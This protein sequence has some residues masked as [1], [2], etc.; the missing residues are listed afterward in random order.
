[1]NVLKPRLAMNYTLFLLLLFS[2]LTFAQNQKRFWMSPASV[3]ADFWTMFEPNTSWDTLRSRIDVFSIHVNAFG[4]RDTAKMW[5]A[6]T[7]LRNAGV[8]VNIEAG[9][10]RPFSGCD[11]LAGER[12]A[13]L[14]LSQMQRWLQRGG[15]I[16]FVTMD[17]PINTMILNG[18]PSG[19]CNW[20]VQR[21]ANEMVDYMK[22]VRAQIPGVVFALVEPVPWY[23]VGSFPPHPGNNYG[24]LLKTLDTVL[25][26]IAQ[27]GETLGIF[28][29]D[30]PYEYGQ[31]SFTKGWKKIKAVEDWLHA[32]GIRHGRIHNSQEGGFTSDSLFFERTLDSRRQYKAVGGDEDEIEVWCWYAHPA[33]NWPETQPFTFA[34]TCKKF[35]EQASQSKVFATLEP[36]DGKVYHGIQTVFGGHASYIATLDS[37]TQPAVRGIFMDVPGSRPPQ[38]NFNGLR[39]FLNDAKKIGY[40]PEVSLFLVTS[41][42][43]PTGATDS[44]IALTT[45]HDEF[46]DSIVTI[47]KTFGGKLFLR[48]GGEFNGWWNGGGYHPYLYPKAFQKIV[49]LCAAKDFRDSVATVWCYYPAAANDFDS[50]DAKGYRWYPGDGYVDWFGLDLFD[51][52]DF[53]PALPDY[54]RGIITR[55]GKS[56]RFLSMARSKG[57]PVFLNETS[58][59]GV[60]I[61]SDPQDGV[62]DWNAW[63]AKFWQFIDNHQEVKGFNYIN[64]HWDVTGFP[65]W[66]DA[67]IENNAYVT[68]QYQAEMRKPKY[69]HLP[70][71]TAPT[72]NLPQQVILIAPANNTMT[73]DSSVNLVWNRSAPNVDL[74]RIH[75]T[76]DASF[77]TLVMNDSTVTDTTR[78][79]GGMTIGSVY[80]WRVQAH[81]ADGW[82]AFSPTWTF[83]RTLDTIPRVPPGMVV[84][85]SP[86]DSSEVI[87]SDVTLVWHRQ[88]P[89]VTR[90]HVQVARDARF[91]NLVLDDVSV[92]DTIRAF[93]GLTQ[94]STYFWRVRAQNV[95]GY[96]PYS[97]VWTFTRKDTT[98]FNPKANVIIDPQIV[99]QTIEGWGASSNFFEEP[100][101]RLPERTRNEIFDLVFEDLGANILCIRL[102]SDFQTSKN[103][104]YNWDVMA[105]QR[106]I[107]NEALRR[108]NIDF[109]W[110]KISSPPGW[111]KT[112]NS[113]ANGGSVKPE[114]Y[115][116]YADFLSHYIRKMKEDY[117]ITIGAVSIFNEPGFVATYESTSTTPEQYRDILKVVGAT[118]ERDGI[119]HVWLIGPE[120]G[121]I[122]QN[123]SYFNTILSDPEAA[124]R[125]Q[126]L[127]T[128]QYGDQLLLYGTGPGDAWPWISETGFR[129]GKRVW[130]TEM[131]VGG[132]NM[133]TND[134]D[135]GLRLALLMW[136]AVTNGQVTAW[137]YWQY[138]FPD[139][140][141]DNKSQGLIPFFRESYSV[142]PRYHVFKHWSKN[143]KRGAV[144]VYAAN[145][146]KDLHVAAFTQQKNAVIVAFNRTGNDIEATFTSPLFTDSVEH[147]RTSATESYAQ[148][149]QLQPQS[150]SITL[151]IRSKSI[152]T[153]IIP[154]GTSGVDEIPAPG[155]IAIHAYP[156]P[157]ETQSL[158]SFRFPEAGNAVITL[159]DVL[160]RQV[161]LLFDGR[162]IRTLDLSLDAI[163]LSPGLYQVRVVMKGTVAMRLV[164]V[165]K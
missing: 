98:T 138:I 110:L 145:D 91:V 86:R 132:P 113:A 61:T 156:H 62:N 32:R 117:G 13:Q 29:S 77:N 149:P 43:S 120:T 137:H 90:Y 121:N 37:T 52:E 66:G 34:Y 128:H 36:P 79:F 141:S 5:G 97:D 31:N 23:S 38:T 157:V 150:Q 58:A 144:R 80:H 104:P 103:G 42:A 159:H 109:I 127:T 147:I 40:I 59:K 92:R 6:A 81:N 15:E 3:R 107:V 96:G 8:K 126:R 56:E 14:E 162:T 35:F 49:D 99:H 158:L 136:N 1:M 161:R 112:N 154:Q 27:R 47:M 125:I 28:H 63:F 84:L 71:G 143:I 105:S 160:G 100:V 122:G 101:A 83:E 108:G 44:V 116:D 115:Q 119:G 53:D 129:N 102:Y 165:S 85:I 89:V 68:A 148:Q 67:R 88:Q 76:T 134:I 50:L 30:S 75:V 124:S 12:H 151:P 118:F 2:S 54:N 146:N 16:H 39:S 155:S 73:M 135:E 152:S 4:V 17:S 95:I 111:M 19:T 106:L 78:T 45:Q 46:L 25:T 70:T 41:Q 139:E 123:Q 94:G 72:V 7:M 153:L 48:I 93:S 57:K 130:E 18:D 26:V 142:Y 82:G 133:A 24:D 87:G 22:A 114:H 163:T 65:G 51:A 60:T 9:G 140:S 164:V 64:Q 69:I 131:Y 74:Y 11:S 10:L 20:T 55:K 21:A 33:A